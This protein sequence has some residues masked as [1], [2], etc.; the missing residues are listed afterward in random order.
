MC[1][2]LLVYGETAIS[3]W[4]L[5]KDTVT[6]VV[7]VLLFSI[8]WLSSFCISYINYLSYGLC[9]ITSCI[10]WIGAIPAAV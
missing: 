4:I 9:L 10:E 7:S 8:S 5:D 1:Y 3:E 2:M 6:V